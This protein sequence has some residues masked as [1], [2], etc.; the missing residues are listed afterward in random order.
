MNNDGEMKNGGYMMQPPS[1]K[2][3]SLQYTERG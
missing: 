2:R 1:L 3:L